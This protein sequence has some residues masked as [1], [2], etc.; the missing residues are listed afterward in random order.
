MEV[1]T[2][3]TKNVIKDAKLVPFDVTLAE[4]FETRDTYWWI[5]KQTKYL[6]ASDP[7]TFTLLL[8]FFFAFETNFVFLA[9]NSKIYSNKWTSMPLYGPGNIGG[10]LHATNQ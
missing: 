2:A 9:F 8:L 3:E 5:Q 7:P 6:F 1:G 10:M 4:S